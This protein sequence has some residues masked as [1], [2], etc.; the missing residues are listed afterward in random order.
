MSDRAPRKERDRTRRVREAV[1]QVLDQYEGQ[2]GVRQIWYRLISPPF[3]LLPQTQGSYKQFD[4]WMVRWRET[5]EVP[6]NRISDRSTAP[7]GGE[8]GS[9]DP[10]DFLSSLLDLVDADVYSR[11][12]WPSQPVVPVVYIEKDTLTGVISDAIRDLGV[13][14]FP[15]RGVTSFTK[16]W[17]LG[18]S[19]DQRVHVLYLTDHDPT[20]VFMGDDFRRRLTRYGGAGIPVTR[21]ALTTDQVRRFKLPPN[22]VHPRDSRSPDYARQFGNKAWELD[23]LPPD[24]LRTIVRGA[25]VDFINKKAW[26]DQD[27]RESAERKSLRTDLEPVRDLLSQLLAKSSG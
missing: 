12:R 11:N 19:S 26:A 17:R 1:L 22:P 4:A 5:G 15:T 21:I 8:Y 6:P 3:Q 14:V 16:L 9:T 24:E 2:L 25:V 7:T 20:G 13:V 18:Q 23:A 10:K 27:L